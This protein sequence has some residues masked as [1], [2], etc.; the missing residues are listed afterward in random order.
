MD[1]SSS[2]GD[3]PEP[4][5]ST[6]FAQRLK[7]LVLGPPQ[8]LFDKRIFHRLSVVAFLAWVGLGADGLSSSCY[9]PEE[10]FRTIGTHTY[11]AIALAAM[12]TLTVAT[13]AIA[14]SRVIEHFPHGGGGYV[15]ATTLLGKRAGVV[16]GSALLIDYVL[17]I[18]V[19]IAAAG[20][21]LFSFLPP[22]WQTVKLPTEVLLILGLTILNMRGV[23]ESILALLPVFLL[24]L[25]THV[26]LIL[27]GLLAHVSEFPAVTEKVHADFT[28]G[29]A[30]LGVGGMVMLLIHAYSLGGGTYTGIEAVSNGLPIMREPRVKTGRHTMIYMATSLAITA[31]GLIVC[32]L[33]WNVAPME[34]KTMN[35][36][37]A[38]KFVSVFPLGYT[39][40]ILTLISEGALLVVAAQ[41]GFVDGP[42]VLANM[43]T[44]S[45]VPHR[46]ATLS[47][48]LITQN[49]ILLMGAAAL[50]ALLYTGGDVRHLVVMYSINVFLTFS[51]TELG[52]CRFWFGSRQTRAD[53]KRKIS[54]HIVGLVMCFTIFVVIVRE[55]FTEGGWITLFVTGMVVL[56]CFVINRHY[57]TLNS[58][59]NSLFDTLA[60]VPPSSGVRA[61]PRFS[62][63]GPIA[64]V[65]VGGSF[66]LGIHTTLATLR[67]FPGLFKNFVFVSVGVVSQTALKGDDPI[68]KLKEKTQA[69]L[70]K[71]VDFLEE[72][73]FAAISSMAIGID[74]VAEL[75]KLCLDIAGK[76]REVTFFAGQ[77]VF[78]RERWYQPILHNQTA[79]SL[80]KRLQ[81]AGHTLIIVPTRVY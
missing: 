5:T 7:R 42:R 31:S 47:D 54:I 76:F 51:M 63:D 15:V 66:G 48:R 58:K 65:L 14:Y 13:I 21:A 56:L 43:A 25:L 50:A 12:V 79:Y 24:F 41:A 18:T 19:S 60:D 11:L 23:K 80:Q 33:L 53:W 57:R 37:L 28:A 4:K 49:G 59:L 46:F 78:R 32:Y 75:E 52:M 64:V 70:T 20:D 6:S 36:V 40:V 39:F 61:K 35:A 22:G 3:E 29:L 62:D 34:G 9:G 30:T 8:D 38:E 72:Q 67:M 77:L 2:S 1:N 68:E 26:I 73:G 81:L 71:Y 45:W 17:T 44:D 55:K 27:G 69:D 10:T 16:S 74:A